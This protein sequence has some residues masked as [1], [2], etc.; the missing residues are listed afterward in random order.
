MALTTGLLIP[1]APQG[2]E[3]SI[4]PVR[5]RPIVYLTLDNLDKVTMR[6]S[7]DEDG[8]TVSSS[9]G[10]SVAPSASLLR[11]ESTAAFDDQGRVSGS[12]QMNQHLTQQ[13]ARD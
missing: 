4:L 2:L 7:F 11:E 9:S 1:S 13:S 6:Q 12:M 3:T 8:V 5:P 10:V